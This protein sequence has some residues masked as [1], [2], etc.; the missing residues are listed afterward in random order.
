M[1]FCHF[2]VFILGSSG[3]LG[4]QKLILGNLSFVNF[5]TEKIKLTFVN[6]CWYLPSTQSV[7]NDIFAEV[8]RMLFENLYPVLVN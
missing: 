2:I 4:K 3:F 8:S 5:T 6:I 7:R 1:Y